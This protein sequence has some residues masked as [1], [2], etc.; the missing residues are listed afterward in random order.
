MIFVNSP[1]RDISSDLIIPEGAAEFCQCGHQR[2]EH[3]P[4]CQVALGGTWGV[5]RYPCPCSE[6]GTDQN[7]QRLYAWWK[8]WSDGLNSRSRDFPDNLSRPQTFNEFLIW[9]RARN[10]DAIGRGLTRSR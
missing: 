5:D 9:R 7:V 6:F 10:A 8:R 4:A 3:S 2:S 1:A